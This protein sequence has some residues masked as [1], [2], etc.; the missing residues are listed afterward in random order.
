MVAADFGS[1]PSDR[2]SCWSRQHEQ[3][4]VVAQ[5]VSVLEAN[6]KIVVLPMVDEQILHSMASQE[7]RHAVI[8]VSRLVVKMDFD[9]CAVDFA[10]AAVESILVDQDAGSCS[11]D[12]VGSSS[13]D[14]C[15]MVQ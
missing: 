11:M 4:I 12:S 13:S 6:A 10:D 3:A 2:S 8:G 15:W 9:S 5:L 14:P 1:E 7:T